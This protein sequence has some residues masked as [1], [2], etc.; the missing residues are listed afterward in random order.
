MTLTLQDSFFF[1]NHV[2]V[3]HLIWFLFPWLRRKKKEDYQVM[4]FFLLHATCQAILFD[5]NELGVKLFAFFLRLCL[6]YQYLIYYF[7]LWCSTIDFSPCKSLHA[8]FVLKCNVENFVLFILKEVIREY[9]GIIINT[10]FMKCQKR[11]K[12]DLN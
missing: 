10:S 12:S 11:G 6:P 4:T 3:Y 8:I 7:I 2:S 1:T 5:Q 9:R